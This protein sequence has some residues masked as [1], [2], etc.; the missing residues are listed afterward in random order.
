MKRLY[1]SFIRALRGL[2]RAT[3]LLG[4]LE[5]G[6]GRTGVRLWLRSLFAIYDLDDL[7]RLD[8]PWW[9]LK[10]T[11]AV[12]AFLKSRPD[13]RVFEYGSGASTFWLAKRAGTVVSV[14][15]DADWYAS[16]QASGL[17]GHVELIFRAP[18]PAGDAAPG[19]PSGR[20]GYEQME[21]RAY[22]QAIEAQ[23]QP[24]DLIVVDGRARVACLEAAKRHLAPGGMIVFD[25]A[26]RERYQKGIETSGLM[27]KCHQGL[28]ACLPYP[29]STCLL[30]GRREK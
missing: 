23:P 13:A 22:V 15:H 19:F 4:W 14:E 30:T 17:P 18:E 2:L 6:G 12:D 20:A 28:T 21:F 5:K 16:M 3:G 24:F 25:N 9:T 11:E 7:R 8:L 29:D 1:V 10:A 26:G 27:V